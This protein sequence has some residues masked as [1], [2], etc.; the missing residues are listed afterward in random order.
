MRKGFCVPAPFWVRTFG[1][2]WEDGAC[3]LGAWVDGRPPAGTWEYGVAGAFPCGSAGRCL[4]ADSSVLSRNNSRINARCDSIVLPC[5]TI[6]MVIRAYE[7][8]KRT[9]NR[10]SHPFLLVFFAGAG[11]ISKAG[12]LAVSTVANNVVKL[13]PGSSPQLA[14]CRRRCI[15]ST[16]DRIPSNLLILHGLACRWWVAGTL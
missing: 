3:A 1:S 5:S 2:V 11:T 6:S 13:H 9:V 10:G 16:N 7:I 14:G 8:R 4:I 12:V 15:P